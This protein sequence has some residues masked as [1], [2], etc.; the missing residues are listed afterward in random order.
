MS[1]PTFCN[2]T[3]VSASEIC[4]DW[5]EE[6]NGDRV[7]TLGMGNIDGNDQEQEYLA[8][9]TLTPQQARE[10]AQELLDAAAQVES[11]MPLPKDVIVDG[12]TGRC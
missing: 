10:M 3:A 11:D 7:V 6:L 8:C 12:P 1:S 2:A 4:A 9:V 5:D